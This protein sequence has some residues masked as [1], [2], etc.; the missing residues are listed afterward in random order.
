MPAVAKTNAT[1][2]KY[3]LATIVAEKT[4][5]KTIKNPIHSTPPK[6]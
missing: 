4:A 3:N 6:K 2:E 5:S 1:N